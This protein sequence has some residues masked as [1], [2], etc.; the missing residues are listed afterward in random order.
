[1][2]PFYSTHGTM[3][4]YVAHPARFLHKYVHPTLPSLLIRQLSDLADLYC[5]PFTSHSSTFQSLLNLIGSP[6]P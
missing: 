6:T 3:A 1:M 4:R 2:I 5:H